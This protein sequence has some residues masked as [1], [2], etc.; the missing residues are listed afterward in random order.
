MGC[1]V[2]RLSV[3]VVLFYVGEEMLGSEI[4]T[5][6]TFCQLFMIHKFLFGE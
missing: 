3:D 6:R 1:L 4:C 2:E 5:E